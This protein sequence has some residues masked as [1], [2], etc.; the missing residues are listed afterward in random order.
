MN[1]DDPTLICEWHD[2]PDA[3]GAYRC[4]R[5]CGSFASSR[6]SIVGPCPA[7]QQ[8]AAMIVASTPRAET[9]PAGPSH[10]EQVEKIGREEVTE[11]WSRIKQAKS[12][13]REIGRWILAGCPIRT[14]DE[15]RAILA[16]CVKCP[17]AI[18]EG[19]AITC[20][21]CGCKT[22]NRAALSPDD[23]GLKIKMGTTFCPATPPRW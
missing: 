21:V 14:D 3:S 2:E 18:L 17:R 16:E 1:I 15:Q 6:N 20:G 11:V 13:V 8:R 23:F 10:D 22:G 12:L 9:K 4:R 5:G 19:D 7:K